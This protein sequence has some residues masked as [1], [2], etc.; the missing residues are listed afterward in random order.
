MSWL[1][2]IF[3]S[4]KTPYIPPRSPLAVGLNSSSGITLRSDAAGSIA[5]SSVSSSG[6]IYELLR[7]L[8]KMFGVTIQ[9]A[10][11]V[12]GS[13]A[14]ETTVFVFRGVLYIA[15]SGA[16]VVFK[17]GVLLGAKAI[18]KTLCTEQNLELGVFGFGFAAGAAA[19]A[20]PA[21][22]YAPPVFSYVMGVTGASIGGIPSEALIALAVTK[23]LFPLILM[24]A[25]GAVTGL[26]CVF[27]VRATKNYIVSLYDL[28]VAGPDT[29]AIG[30]YEA[31]EKPRLLTPLDAFI[32]ACFRARHNP[33]FVYAEMRKITFEN[34]MA[35][36]VVGKG[37]M[38]DARREMLLGD[39]S[40]SGLVIHQSEAIIWWLSGILQMK[41]NAGD[42]SIQ[43]DERALYAD[44]LTKLKIE[45]EAHASSRERYTLVYR[46]V[47]TSEE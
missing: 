24:G 13:V 45:A 5:S 35:E 4:G 19:S 11:S 17:D 44:I 43:G 15:E 9:S 2:T 28:Y 23:N 31:E 47:E 12:L 36:I 34:G 27:V 42:L 22:T 6:E 21:F 25:T 7:E 40:Q 3:G 32:L 10:E 41:N 8:K 46:S 16:T 14:K 20:M 30:K 38:E 37:E 33:A 1:S 18:V 26:L 29:H 39:V